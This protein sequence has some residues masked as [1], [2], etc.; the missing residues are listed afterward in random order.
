MRRLSPYPVL[1]VGGLVGGLVL[2]GCGSDANPDSASLS[3][4]GPSVSNG[5]TLVSMW[6]LTGLE[7]T[8]GENV[9]KRHPVIVTKIDNTSSA[10]P[11][12]GLGSA[13][14]VVEE[15][16]EG[17]LTRLAVFYYSVLPEQVGPVRSMRASDIGI[18][19]PVGGSIVTSGAAAGTKA[20]IS[21]AGI[22]FYEEGA[23]GLYRASDRAAPYN[24]LADLT[25][26]A[27][28][29]A[30]DAARPADYL[31][32]GA[33][34]DLP[35]GRPVRALNAV[36]SGG[37]TTS[38]IYRDGGY[39]N[40]NSYAAADDQFPADTVLVLRVPVGDAGYLDP[41]GNPVPETKLVGQGA[42][43]LLHGGKLVRGTWSKATLDA[44]LEL[45]TKTGDL[46]VPPGRVWIEL[47]P[48][49]GGDPRFSN[50]NVSLR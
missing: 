38:W 22:D 36:F 35:Q 48:G 34:D 49:A 16:V 2:A 3:G 29:A 12:V 23:A 1:L 8:A 19:S 18:V 40:T 28:T 21:A 25:K 11:Q 4:A 10:S 30:G 9:A 27:K 39:V 26:V 43:L 15:M 31:P 46:T 13:D 37:H 6:P 7:A 47:V 41:A 42:A 24:V 5:R 32:W 44:P 20:K 50:G 17:G 45:S 33:E 14:L